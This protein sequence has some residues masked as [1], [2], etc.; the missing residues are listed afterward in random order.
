MPERVLPEPVSPEI[1][2]PLQKSSRVQLKPF[3]RTMYLPFVGSRAV[4]MMNAAIPANK[5]AASHEYD[6]GRKK[7]A[8]A[9]SAKD[10]IAVMKWS[11][12]IAKAKIFR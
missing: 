1:N 11:K 5:I 2:H 4:V 7:S 10:K 3:S 9:A 12:R 8:P 6:S